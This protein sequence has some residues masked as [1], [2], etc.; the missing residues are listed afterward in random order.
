MLVFSISDLTQNTQKIFEAAQTEEVII[1][2]LDGKSYRLLPVR[3][4]GKSPF[5]N[6]PRIKLGITTQEIIE[7]I[8]ESR[9]GAK[10]G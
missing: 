7:I 5:D 10:S 4:N 1:N 8:K 2:N 3:K 9:A 6:V